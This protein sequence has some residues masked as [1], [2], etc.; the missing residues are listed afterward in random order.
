MGGDP[1]YLH[2][3]KLTEPLK[4]DG[5]NTIVSFWGVKRPIFRGVAGLFVSG[6]VLYHLE[7]IP[8]N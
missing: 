8:K 7:V 3:L 5:W 1:N 6:S 2:C 4:M